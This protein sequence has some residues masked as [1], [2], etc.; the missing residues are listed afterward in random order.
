MSD[1]D[2]GDG[3]GPDVHMAAPFGGETFCGLPLAEAVPVVPTHGRG[4]TCDRCIEAWGD[5]LDALDWA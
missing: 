3:D 1:Y 4:A 5:G 2:Q